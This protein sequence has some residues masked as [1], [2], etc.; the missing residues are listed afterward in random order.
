MCYVTCCRYDALG[1]ETS[2]RTSDSVRSV[3]RYIVDINCYIVYHG[4]PQC[5]CIVYR[6]RQQFKKLSSFYK[7]ASSLQYYR[8][9]LTLPVLP[10]NPPNFLQQVRFVKYNRYMLILQ[11]SHIFF[12]C[13]Y[14]E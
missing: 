10:S 4:C 8:N 3:T 5:L 11:H 6:F 14:Y 13:N 7:H 1:Y 12:Y 9:L 2:Y